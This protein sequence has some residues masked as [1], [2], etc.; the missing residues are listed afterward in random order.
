MQVTSKATVDVAI[1][2]DLMCPWCWVGLRNL[3]AASK[4]SNIRT[5]ITWKPFMLRPNIPDDGQPKDGTPAS[6]VGTHLRQAGEMAGI[7]FTGLTD[8]TPNTMLFHATLK[9]LQDDPHVDAATVTEYHEAVFEGYF[10]LGVFP[11]EKGLLEAATKLNDDNRVAS[12]IKQLY[13][14][15]SIL[16]KHKHEV[17]QE[18]DEASYSGISGV[19]TF[20]FNGRRAFSGGQSVSTF[21]SY[22][23]HFAAQNNAVDDK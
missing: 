3:Q 12:K 20:E 2:S 7:N 16:D 5:N 6:R 23:E 18:A 22:L 4:Q 1:T 10:T 11:D 21:A 9:M 19:P 15:S 13:G 8:R 14:D 17:R